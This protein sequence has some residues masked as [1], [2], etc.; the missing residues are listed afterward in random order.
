MTTYLPFSPS[1]AA[2]PPWQ[3]Q[4]T[5]DGVTYNLTATWSP[6]GQRWYINLVALDG[7]SL[8]YTARVGSPNA[9]Q[10]ESISWAAGGTANTGQV[11]VETSLPHGFTIGDVVTVTIAG[12]TPDAY[13]GQYQCLVTGPSTLT[14]PLTADPG[15]ATMVGAV[16]QQVN[17]V[18]GIANE[19]GDYFS[20]TLVF[21][22]STQNFEISP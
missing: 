22:T 10:I 7:T 12:C 9:L 3:G 16:N 2:N 17:L 8:L 1:Q 19:S 20:S 4:I 18:G 13:N 6:F 15:T 21:R 5:L 11:T 14:F